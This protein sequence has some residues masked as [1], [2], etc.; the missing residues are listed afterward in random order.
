MNK[1]A[2]TYIGGILLLSC[3][4]GFGR[5]NSLDSLKQLLST[6]IHSFAQP[7]SQLLLDI[8]LQLGNAYVDA[9]HYDSAVTVFTQGLAYSKDPISYTRMQYELAYCYQLLSNYPEAITHSK[10]AM[11][12]ATQE[13]PLSFRAGIF[14]QLA[15]LHVNWG[16]LAKA[17]KYEF[18]GLHLAEQGQDSL[19]MA[20][21]YSGLARIY[22]YAEQNEKALNYDL[23]ALPIKLAI[24][25]PKDRYKAYVDVASSY[26]DVGSL[27]SALQYAQ[28]ANRE[29]TSMDFTHGKAFSSLVIG[30]IYKQQDK[31]DQAIEY[32][33][34]ARGTFRELGRTFPIAQ[35]LATLGDVLGM[36]KDFL[37]AIDT[38]LSALSLADSLGY[39][40]LKI[41][42]THNLAQLYEE[43][44]QSSE[45]DTYKALYSDLQGSFQK[46]E[47]DS[48]NVLELQLKMAELESEY[49]QQQSLNQLNLVQKEQA[50]KIRRLYI[51][52]LSLGSLLLVCLLAFFHARYRLYKSRTQELKRQQEEKN[53]EYHWQK[54]TSKDWQNLA[55][56]LYQ[57]IH[58]R[59]LAL[60]KDFP[61]KED[62]DSQVFDQVQVPEE[63]QPIPPMQGLI[64]EIDNYLLQLKSYIQAGFSGDQVELIS[65]KMLIDESLQL[66]NSQQRQNLYLVQ[67]DLPPLRGDRKKLILLV[68]QLLLV[69]LEAKQEDWIEIH[70]RGN[71]TK[72]PGTYT[73]DYEFNFEGVGEIPIP[74]TN[75]HLE[76]CKKIIHLY[77]G[78]LWVDRTEKASVKVNFTLPLNRVG[79]DIPE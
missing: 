35:S 48:L 7:D 55:D 66:L 9:G 10:E 65:F 17:L 29:A 1:F 15:Q 61:Y 44:G 23:K 21:T 51:I 38:L 79:I 42:L 67:H 64:S 72:D 20:K 54:T 31:L 18:K 37:P 26:M 59:I 40:S 77:H 6:H 53:W 14:H 41:D 39:H 11:K 47:K 76:V 3:I 34:G 2:Y 50:L 56:K 13:V 73:V 43:V 62:S 28:L 45:A 49:F 5:P 52:L 71:F 58:S 12:R 68:Q 63:A 25:E 60:G 24:G 75:W 8:H 32:I 70:V 19:S 22:Y 74:D 27:D 16:K 46:E 57:E 78:K 4:Q 33:N 30:E 36:N 69:F